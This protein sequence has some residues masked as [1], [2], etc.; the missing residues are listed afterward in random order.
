MG[1]SSSTPIFLKFQ[2]YPLLKLIKMESMLNGLAL[3]LVGSW[4]GSMV[5]GGGGGR[6][7][8][9]IRFDLSWVSFFF[10]CVFEL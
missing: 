3:V 7:L 1:I 8:H 10:L 2:I 5:V 4:L 9:S 6:N